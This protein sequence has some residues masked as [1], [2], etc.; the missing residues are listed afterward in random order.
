MKRPIEF[1]C[2]R[3]TNG[4]VKRWWGS[5]FKTGNNRSSRPEVFCEK[6][7]LRNFPKFTS[8]PE[9]LF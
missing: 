8:V 5:N 9:S 6:C 7:V 3:F 1:F 4:G 2:D